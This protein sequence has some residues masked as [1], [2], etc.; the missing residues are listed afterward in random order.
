MEA[1]WSEFEH[2]VRIR[3]WLNFDKV[4]DPANYARNNQIERT[5]KQLITKLLFHFSLF[6]WMKLH[7]HFTWEK[8]N[9]YFLQEIES[10]QIC[11]ITLFRN[12]VKK[13]AQ[14]W[15]IKNALG[16]PLQKKK[17]WARC[18]ENTKKAK[19]SKAIVMIWLSQIK[20]VVIQFWTLI[21]YLVLNSLKLISSKHSA[22]AA[23]VFFWRCCSFVFSFSPNQIAFYCFIVRFVFHVIYSFQCLTTNRCLAVKSWANWH[24]AKETA[25]AKVSFV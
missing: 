10:N 23:D 21:W 20:W 22:V 15:W 3:H 12:G 19:A 14:S 2:F 13:N 25:K 16:K 17:E 4:Y 7:Y 5:H 8:E 18:S 24:S 9:D 11:K 6:V 1:K